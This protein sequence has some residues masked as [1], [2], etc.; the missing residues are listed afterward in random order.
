MPES[1][2]N[3]DALIVGEVT[4]R[5]HDALGGRRWPIADVSVEQAAPVL[6]AASY[7]VKQ[8]T[9]N[10]DEY[11]AG[12]KSAIGLVLTAGGLACSTSRAAK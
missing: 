9:S 8:Q 10:R 6:Q 7:G 2:P 4:A 5:L 11:L 3:I 1:V 12:M